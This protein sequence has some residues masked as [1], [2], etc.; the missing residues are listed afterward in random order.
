MPQFLQYF[1]SVMYQQV[2]T[3]AMFA[4]IFLLVIR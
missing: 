2:V 4:E 3:T 1:D